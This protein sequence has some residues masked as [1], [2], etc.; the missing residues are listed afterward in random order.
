M[1]IGWISPAERINCL[2]IIPYH[3]QV[4]IVSTKQLYDLILHIID[5]LEFVNQNIPKPIFPSVT[6][7]GIFRQQSVTIYQYIMTTK[8]GTYLLYYAS[9]VQCAPETMEEYRQME[10]EIGDIRFVV[11]NALN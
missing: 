4:F 10:S 3:K 8:D 6:K 5:I 1:H 2:I 9:D 7:P 11:D